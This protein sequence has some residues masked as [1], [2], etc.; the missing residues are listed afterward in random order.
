MKKR[1][2]I[3]F[4]VFIILTFLESGILME[5]L[6]L[7]GLSWEPQFM[8]C[9][10]AGETGLYALVYFI[11]VSIIIIFLNRIALCIEKRSGGKEFLGDCICALF[12]IG[13]G[14]VVNFDAPF[15]VRYATP[16]YMLGIWMADFLIDF[17]DWM[18][19]MPP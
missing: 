3:V 17:F 4:L 11:P 18:R 16:V 14:I 12:G 8:V 7:N 13:I 1:L 10:E 5:V 9:T 6:W 15:Q 2:P 19:L